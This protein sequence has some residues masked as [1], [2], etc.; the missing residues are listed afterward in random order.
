V[1]NAN[2]RCLGAVGGW[3]FFEKERKSGLVPSRRQWKRGRTTNRPVRGFGAAMLVEGF[4]PP[5]YRLKI[6]N[7]V[8]SSGSYHCI[9]TPKSE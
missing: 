6:K 7:P 1:I 8:F 4:G 9:M 3:G 2:P 5:E